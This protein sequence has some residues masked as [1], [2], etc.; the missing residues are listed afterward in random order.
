MVLS[1]KSN[2]YITDMKAFALKIIG[3][4]SP[5]GDWTYT[6]IVLMPSG[7]G[8]LQ[9]GLQPDI[10]LFPLAGGINKSYATVFLG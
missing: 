7:H 2:W 6:E 1:L 10:G 4:S 9:N 3:G 5:L 8:I